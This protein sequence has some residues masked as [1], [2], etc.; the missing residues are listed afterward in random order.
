MGNLE[1]RQAWNFSAGIIVR[2]TSQSWCL[3]HTPRFSWLQHDIQAAIARILF[4]PSFLTSSRERL[5]RFFQYQR[6][7][8]IWEKS[9]LQN[10]SLEQYTVALCGTLTLHY[11]WSFEE[12]Q[13]IF[14]PFTYSR[15]ERSTSTRRGTTLP[16]RCLQASSKPDDSLPIREMCG[17]RRPELE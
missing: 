10:S 14:L 4:F 7:E 1:R 5:G 12:Q 2:Q 15:L 17:C 16:K 11:L 3:T 9:R 8:D 6:T 13:W